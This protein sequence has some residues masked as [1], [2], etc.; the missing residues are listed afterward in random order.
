MYQQDSGGDKVLQSLARFGIF[1]LIA[2]LAVT[3]F[4]G[5]QLGREIATARSGS[6]LEL[7]ARVAGTGATELFEIGQSHYPQWVTK[8][9]AFWIALR[10]SE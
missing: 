3:A 10:L 4:C 7:G 1:A 9:P 5:I 8:S 6:L 2:Y